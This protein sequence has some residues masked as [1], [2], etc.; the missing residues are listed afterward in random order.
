MK[1]ESIVQPK[2][3]RKLNALISSVLPKSYKY[4]GKVVKL[5][6]DI[7]FPEFEK[8]NRD[9]KFGP[10]AH[11]LA[12]GGDL[13]VPRMLQ[14]YKLGI[15]PFFKPDE[16]YLWWTADER[17]VLNLDNLHIERTMRKLLRKSE[18][19]VTSD[20]AFS[21]VIE[22]CR[23]MHDGYE[24]LNDDRVTAVYRLHEAGYVH[25]IE[26]WKEDVLVGG[27]FG[28]QI[29][30]YFYAESMF[31]LENNASKYGFLAISLR[32]HELGFEFFDEGI[33]P[34]KHIESTG[35]VMVPRD[36]FLSRVQVAVDVSDAVPDWSSLF[37]NWDSS[38]SITRFLEKQKSIKS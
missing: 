11:L 32:L 24:W 20:R 13:S 7:V 30:Y 2:V 21:E 33:W 18:F 17:C 1:N 29:G 12:Y 28:I 38:E 19:V 8:A 34:T 15:I 36:E 37:D 35:A 6:N 16:P 26:V 3:T 14:A 10:I 4:S 5:S 23:S 25:S 27:L 31:A 22:N 9:F